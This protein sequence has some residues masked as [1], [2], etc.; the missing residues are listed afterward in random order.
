M[1]RRPP[2]STLFPYTTLFR[3]D[4]Q[5]AHFLFNDTRAAA[6]WLGVRLYVG[7]E[8]L[9]AGLHKVTDPKWMDTGAALKAYFERAVAVPQPPAR[10]AITYDWYRQ[11]LQYLLD[12]QTYTW[13]AK[14]VAIGE[15][16]VGV[17]LLVGCLVG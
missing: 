1:I 16:L 6:L 17:G 14:L 2:R 9:S 7:Y 15:V 4:P 11:F 12:Q 13:F 5:I 3:S 10:A 8:W